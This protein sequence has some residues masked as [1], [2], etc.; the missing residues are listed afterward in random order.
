M[1]TLQ[2]SYKKLI[3][4]QK[5]DNL[6]YHI[7][8]ATKNFPKKELYGITSQIRRAGL[9]VPANIAE[10]AGRQNRKEKKQFINIALGSLVE[11]EYLLE[12]SLRLGFIDIEAYN[13]IELL[14]KS[15]GALLWGLYKSL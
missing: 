7:Y 2:K 10:G 1:E 5:A 13:N 15:T 4:W 14:R 11:T 9:S 8:F 12:F 6:A 3:A